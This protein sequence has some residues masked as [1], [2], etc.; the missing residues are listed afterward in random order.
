M[1]EDEYAKFLHKIKKGIDKLD[2]SDFDSMDENLKKQVNHVKEI[3]DE[4]D[5]E[6]KNEESTDQEAS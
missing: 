3:V 5:T 1:I 6:L 2:D 4:L